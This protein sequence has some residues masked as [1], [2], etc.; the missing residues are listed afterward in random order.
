MAALKLLSLLSLCTRTGLAASNGTT[1]MQIRLAYAGDTGM[2]VSWNTYLQPPQP[3]VQYGKHPAYLTQ[4]A[5]SNVSVTHQ[6]ST[7]YNNHKKLEGL[8]PGSTYY[9]QPQHSNT[10]TPFSFKASRPAGD[11]TPFVAAVVVDL[12]TMGVDG[13]TTH[14]GTGAANPLTPGETNTIQSLQ[15]FQD[16]YEFLMHGMD[17]DPASCHENT[18]RVML[19][20]A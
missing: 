20:R 6:T 9:Y 18:R 7:T 16:E 4:S 19:T 10:S 3:T 13:L 1:P 12:G 8:E 11:H 14:V 15:D 5:S 17:S 2:Y